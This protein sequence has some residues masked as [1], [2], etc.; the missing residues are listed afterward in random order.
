METKKKTFAQEVI[1]KKVEEK[2]SERSI[3]QDWNE[4]EE[5]YGSDYNDCHGDYYDVEAE[6]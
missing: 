3:F 1:L 2:L 5:S 6:N 4:Y